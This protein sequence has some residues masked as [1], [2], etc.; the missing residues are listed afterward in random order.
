VPRQA[1]PGGARRAS[2]SIATGTLP[3]RVETPR[4]VLRRWAEGDV[5]AM[6]GIW[7]DRA[8]WEALRPGLP[9]DATTGRERLAYH[10]R[11]W[12]RHGYGTYAAE[13]RRSGEV[14]GWVGP[15][16]PLFVPELASRVELGWTL[17]RP[18]WGRGLATEGA[19]AA[20]RAC[21]EHLGLDELISLIHPANPRSAAVAR[22]LGMSTARRVRHPG[23]GQDLEV[24]A[25]SRPTRTEQPRPAGRPK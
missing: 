18:F 1:V 12:E 23:I 14:A 25:I 22:R 16:H 24:W 13:D 11:H 9:F 4:L 20:L 19:A 3:E 21:F 10:L 2:G 5:E 17:R 6:E 15:S 8:V 7:S